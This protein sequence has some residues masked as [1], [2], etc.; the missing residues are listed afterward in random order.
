MASTLGVHNPLRY[1][2]YVYDAE[3][4]LYY[5][6][7]RYYNPYIGRFINADGVI[8]GVGGDVLGYNQFAYCFNNPVNLFD[9]AG[10]WPKW[11][12]VGLGVVAAA[13]AVVATV[14]TGAKPLLRKHGLRQPLQAG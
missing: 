5:L 9:I 1:R 13:V 6:Q 12:T 8:S 4:G 10:N 2:G 11:L 14:A 3:T 7:S